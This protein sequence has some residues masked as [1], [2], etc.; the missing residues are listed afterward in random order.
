MVVLVKFVSDEM[1]PWT[2]CFFR[3]LISAL[4]LLPLVRRHHAAM[5]QFIRARGGEA[6]FIG[7]IGLGLTQGVLFTAL[8]HTSAV[9]AGIVFATAP[10]ITLALAH[11]V[12]GER[13]NAWQ[14]VG[15]AIAFGGIVL[16]AVQGSLARLLA[17]QLEP[18]DLLALAAAA[19]FA[20]YTVLL[21]RAR[22]ELE[23]LP[24]LVILLASG[25]FAAF[26]SFSSS[27]GAASTPILRP[28]ATSRSST[29]GWRAAR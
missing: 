5:L 11:L 14:A 2:M 25:S 28:G 20:S 1:P 15:S 27:C 16:I 3:V 8:H 24:L 23:R 12:L 17:L 9:S 29:A 10:M 26:R 7:A 22:F 4:V 6:A 18:G 21:K 13:M 19:L